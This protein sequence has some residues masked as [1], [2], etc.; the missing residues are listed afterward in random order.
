M[1][2]KKLKKGNMYYLILH[3]R[4]W[5]YKPAVIVPVKVVKK[6][7][8]SDWIVVDQCID[9]YKHRLTVHIDWLAP[10]QIQFAK[11]LLH[12]MNIWEKRWEA[13]CWRHRLTHKT[14]KSEIT[15]ALNE[16]PKYKQQDISKRFKQIYPHLLKPDNSFKV[17]KM[18]MIHWDELAW[19]TIALKYPLKIVWPTQKDE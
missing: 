3:K 2:A 16:L 6:T 4:D 5:T 19:A 1:D 18:K 11:N 12:N 17:S 9:D 7:R 15:K 10:Y 14:A 8:F 13:N